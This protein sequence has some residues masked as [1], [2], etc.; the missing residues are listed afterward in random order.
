MSQDYKVHFI[1]PDEAGVIGS[2]GR[3]SNG[4]QIK[5]FS[6]ACDK[7]IGLPQG[8]KSSYSLTGNPEFV[9]CPECQK[10]AVFLALYEIRMEKPFVAVPSPE[11][12]A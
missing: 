5:T 7:N 4:N 11:A 3:S 8:G 9:T 6:C 2:T 12:T 1:Y 10:S